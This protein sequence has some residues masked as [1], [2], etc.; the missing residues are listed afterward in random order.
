MRASRFA[1]DAF[2]EKVC[3]RI[4]VVPAPPPPASFCL[5]GFPL[6]SLCF[7]GSRLSRS[8]SGDR[9]VL[10]CSRSMS[11]LH[12]AVCVVLEIAVRTPRVVVAPGSWWSTSDEDSSASS[13]ERLVLPERLG[14]G[15]TPQPGGGAQRCQPS[16]RQTLGW[17][18]G[19]SLHRVLLAVER[20]LSQLRSFLRG[21]VFEVFSVY[22]TA[23]AY[24]RH[25]G[26]TLSSA[27]IGLVQRILR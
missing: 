13:L 6:V 27:F 11:I 18:L 15:Q 2:L 24:L 3:R 22:S 1:R 9:E 10:R 12:D 16:L 26:G 19:A 23:V 4:V 17:R 21:L 25:Q 7:C 14:L 8:L 20:G 5:H